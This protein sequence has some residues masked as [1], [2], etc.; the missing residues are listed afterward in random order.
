MDVPISPS[1]SL[2]LELDWDISQSILSSSESDSAWNGMETLDHSIYVH[3]TNTQSTHVHTHT[4]Q[5]L[6]VWAPLSLQEHQAE[7][8]H[9][10]LHQSL[11]RRSHDRHMH[12][13]CSCVIVYNTEHL[14]SFLGHFGKRAPSTD[15]SSGCGQNG[16]HSFSDALVIFWGEH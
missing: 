6:Y 13:T 1:T 2:S 5:H 15:K 10:P 16:C 7:Q 3:Y 11:E 4:P 12:I 14:V 8:S 9:D